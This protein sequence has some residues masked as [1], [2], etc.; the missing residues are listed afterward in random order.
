M[1]EVAEMML[2]GTLCKHCGGFI[3]DGNGFT[4]TCHSCRVEHSAAG[5]AKAPGF[6]IK[7]PD[8]EKW[9]KRIGLSNHRRDAHGV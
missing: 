3:G 5:N 8:C 9:V 2:D 1:G 7:C 4:R 6:K